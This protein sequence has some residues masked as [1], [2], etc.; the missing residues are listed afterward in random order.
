M[1]VFIERILVTHRLKA[2]TQREMGSML[3]RPKRIIADLRS[4]SRSLYTW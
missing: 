1:N 3:K 2:K 4:S